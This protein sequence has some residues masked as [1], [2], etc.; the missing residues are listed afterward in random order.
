MT[1]LKS[2]DGNVPPRLPVEDLPL[3]YDRACLL[4]SEPCRC[5]GGW[6]DGAARQGAETSELG[7]NY[8][9]PSRGLGS[10]SFAGLT[11][12]CLQRVAN[13]SIFPVPLLEGEFASCRSLVWRC[14]S[15]IKALKEKMKS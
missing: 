6:G 9:T 12:H 13:I 3:L 15:A 5:H 7:Q 1:R 10:D 8:R 14:G 2:Q 11:G 4:L